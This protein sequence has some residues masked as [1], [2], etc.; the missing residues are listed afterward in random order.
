MPRHVA[1]RP[2]PWRRATT[3]VLTIAATAVLG[4][5]ACDADSGPTEPEL[6]QAGGTP[7]SSLPSSAEP[8]S[9]APENPT[10]LR[11]DSADLAGPSEP[12]PGAVVVSAS[13]SLDDVVAGHPA[14][15]TYWLSPG[16]HRLGSGEY[17]QVIPDA[18]DTFVGAPG[19]VFDG[20]HENRY[21]FAGEA[22]DV[23]IS[24][25]TV[26]NFGSR[27]ENNNEGVVNHDSARGW[28]VDR[29]TIQNNA[30]AG[31][32]LG[33]GSR[34]TGNCLRDN[35]QYGVQRLP[36]RRCR[37]CGAGWKRDLGQ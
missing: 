10:A 12:P 23:T 20:G 24:F 8:A 29:S 6:P 1:A 13:Q 19:A 31:V 26:Q 34:L 35:G 9:A 15:T 33:S 16:T 2:G 17:D 3:V 27:G 14:K 37:G 36:P 32:M 22:P 5:A 7:P 30:G 28:T 11:C 21:A 18:G 25:L 4:V